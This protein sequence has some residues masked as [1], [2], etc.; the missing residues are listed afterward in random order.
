MV[1]RLLCLPAEATMQARARSS[2]EPAMTLNSHH[3]SNGASFLV[4]AIALGGGCA[5]GNDTAN[6]VATRGGHLFEDETF[7]GNGR[8]CRT[9]HSREN[10]TLTPTQVEAL[11][12]SDPGAPLF[13]S[14]DS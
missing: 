6:V 1:R 8:T 11:F 3:R 2:G 14:V 5:S 9:C 12:G 10:G 13:R 7:G 4:V